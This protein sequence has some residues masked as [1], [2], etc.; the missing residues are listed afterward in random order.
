M[1]GRD[2]V[3]K[4]SQHS[5]ALDILQRRRRRIHVDKKWWFSNIGRLFVPGEQFT[6][7]RLKAVPL[8]ISIENTGVA[9]IEHV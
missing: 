3:T 4:I 7:R 1:V 5:G 8:F 9:L 2:A 6:G